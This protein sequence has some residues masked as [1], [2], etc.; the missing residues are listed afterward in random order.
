MVRSRKSTLVVMRSQFSRVDSMIVREVTACY[1]GRL[2]VVS[3]TVVCTVAF[4]RSGSSKKAIHI[5]IVK[6]K[7]YD[8]G[9]SYYTSRRK[10]WSQSS[11]P[12]GMSVLLS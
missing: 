3:A 12:R 2:Y 7:V 1:V 6:H 8:T 5:R 9:S 11:F 10:C 4:R